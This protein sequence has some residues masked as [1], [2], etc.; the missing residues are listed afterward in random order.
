M[1][2]TEIVPARGKWLRRAAERVGLL[3]A[4]RASIAWGVSRQVVGRW[5]RGHRPR[6]ADVIERVAR[7][8]HEDASTFLSGPWLPLTGAPGPEPQDARAKYLPRLQVVLEALAALITEM[9]HDLAG[10]G[11][12][13]LP[14]EG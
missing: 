12:G 1:A 10:E 13:R 4:T 9:E 7:S 11:N 6:E 8:I 3:N 14:R 2:E 5:Y